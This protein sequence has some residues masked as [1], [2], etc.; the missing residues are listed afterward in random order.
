MVD[1][2]VREEDASKINRIAERFNF[3]DIATIKKELE[4]EK[5]I[6]NPDNSQNEVLKSEDEQFID[7]VL[8][9]PRE[10]KEIPSNIKKRRKR[11]CQRFPTIS[12]QKT[13]RKWKLLKKIKN[14]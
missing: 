6:K 3:K 7:D 8:P 9:K 13:K 1:I 5:E 11:I 12:N 14:L 10:Q 2:M 4:Q